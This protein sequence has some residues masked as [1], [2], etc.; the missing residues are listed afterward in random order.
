MVLDETEPIL[1]DRSSREMAGREIPAELVGATHASHLA[2]A[3]VNDAH[4]LSYANSWCMGH[5]S[6]GMWM[7]YGDGGFGI[8]VRSTTEGCKKAL[9]HRVL[10]QY[11]E[12][13]DQSRTHLALD[14]DAPRS[15]AVSPS[16]AGRIIAIPK[17]GGLHHRYERSAA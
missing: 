9:T 14:K 6:L 3:D 8:A 12:Y 16:T 7:L 2:A 1:V 4:E 17:V 10:K 13:Y 11:I 15:R 5:E